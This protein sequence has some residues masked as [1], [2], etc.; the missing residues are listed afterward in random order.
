MEGNPHQLVYSLLRILLPG[1]GQPHR[2]LS[3]FRSATEDHSG[4]DNPDC[5]CGLLDVLF[6]R[7]FAMELCRCLYDDHWRSFLHV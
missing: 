1:S 5:V 7:G 3:I 2:T 6:E 4:S